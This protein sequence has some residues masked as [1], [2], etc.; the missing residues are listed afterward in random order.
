MAFKKRKLS[1][2]ETK[3]AAKLPAFVERDTTDIADT[4]PKAKK[5]T[6]LPEVVSVKDFADISGLPVTE[7]IGQ[8]IKNG[9][10]ANINENIDFETAQIVGDDFGLEVLPKDAQTEEFSEKAQVSDSK[11]LETRPPVVSIMGHVDHGKTSLLD[12]I[13]ETHV[14]AGESGGITQHISAYEIDIPDSEDKSKKRSITF[15]D[16]PGHSAFSAMRSHGASI[17]DIVILIVAADDGVMPQTKE[18]IEQSKLQNV[19]IIVAINKTDLPN[20]DVM[21]IRQQLSEYELIGE[22]WGGK[23]TIIEISAKTGIGVDQLLEMILLQADLMDLKADPRVPATGIVIESHIH[24]GA[25]ALA[26]ILI[27]NGSLKIGD[28]VAIGPVYGKV[29]ILENWM[30]QSIS[31]AGPSTP[32]RV[33]GLKSLPNF[34]ERLVA[35]ESEKEAKT[36]A[37]NFSERNITRRYIAK[38]VSKGDSD[39]VELNLIVKSDVAGSLEAI[40]KTLSEIS[41]HGLKIK[42]ILEGVGPVSESD[43]AM[44]AAT[45]ALILAFRIA[46]SL[47]A[48]K[49]IDKEKIQAIEYQVIYE[50]VDDVKRILEKMLPPIIKENEIGKGKILVEFRN[51][52]K[53]VVIGFRVDEGEFRVGEMV[54]VISNS[55]EIWRG[56]INSLRREKDQVSS[57]SSGTEAGIGLDAGAKYSVGDKIVAFSIEEIPQKL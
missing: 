42:I 14:A 46:I 38:S 53:G 13:R 33:A 23:T 22:D 17:A 31:V 5:K 36:A 56:K 15:I 45:G 7:I 19:P 1:K 18:V 49:I 24:K 20:A 43:A 6:Y 10:L 25:G 51:N 39:I 12:K 37:K 50:L 55:E 30:G 26:V 48:K 3:A 8:L 27:E 2:K 21:K 52:K 54:K 16:T 35:F 28:S 44:A 57:I 34:A 9:V 32:V 11:T 41:N 4:T 47:P 40:K 29:R